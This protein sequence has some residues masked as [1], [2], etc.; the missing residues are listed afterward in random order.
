MVELV[1]TL[2]LEA[3]LRVRVRV[4]PGAPR[5]CIVSSAVER[6]PYKAN[7]SGSTPLRC[8]IEYV[9]IDYIFNNGG[10]LGG[11]WNLS[12]RHYDVVFWHRIYTW[13]VGRVVKAAVC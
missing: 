1:D 3:S 13:R 10:I 5:F 6:R 8:T 11:I 12:S 2:V 7:V 4:P 9:D